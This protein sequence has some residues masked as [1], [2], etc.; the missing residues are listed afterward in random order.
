MSNHYGMCVH[1]L[2]EDASDDDAKAYMYPNE[3]DLPDFITHKTFG[4][5]EWMSACVEENK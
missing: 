4:C 2:P 5:T 3:V 1:I